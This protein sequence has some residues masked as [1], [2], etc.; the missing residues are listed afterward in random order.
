[1]LQVYKKRCRNCL[2]SSDRIVSSER[3]NEIIQECKDND[4]HFICHV[5]TMENSGN[6]CCR[7]FFDTIGDDITKIQIAKRLG[8]I[9]FIETPETEKLPPYRDFT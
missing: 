6:T 3:M 9:E 7:G 8:L 5:S 4:T 2:F 1:M